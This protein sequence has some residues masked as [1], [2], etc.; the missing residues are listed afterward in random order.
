MQHV[1]TILPSA[2]YSPPSIGRFEERPPPFPLSA[3]GEVRLALLDLQQMV[4]TLA[5]R[6]THVKEILPAPNPDYIGQLL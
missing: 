2:P 5:A 3:S 4:T 1:V 6:P